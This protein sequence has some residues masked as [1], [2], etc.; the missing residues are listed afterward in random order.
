MKII[1]KYSLISLILVTL[2]GCGQVKF[3]G[4]NSSNN[5]DGGNNGGGGTVNPNEIRDVVYSGTVQAKNNKIDILLVIDDSNSMLDD[6]K[7]LAS[8]LYTF[9]TALQ[10]L[11]LDWQMCVTLTRQLNIAGN[12]HWGASLHWVN[13]VPQSGVT[14]LVLKPNPANLANIFNSTI[15][16]IGAGWAGTDDERGIMAA[17]WHVANSQ[18]NGC[19]RSDAAL[20]TII[21]SDEDVRSVG[22]D[23][24]L[25]YYANE[26]KELEEN[27]KPAAYVGQV[28]T[29]LGEQKRFTV[30]SIIVND[31]T[32]MTAQDTAGSKSHTG[33]HYAELSTLTGGGVGSIC[34]ADYSANL[35]YFKD[36][37]QNSLASIPLECAPV[38]GV[39]VN[40]TPPMG[41]VTS[42]VQG[43]S[44]VFSPE[45]PTGRTYEVK[46]KCKGPSLMAN[47]HPSSEE[48]QGFFA[49]LY[50]WIVEPILNL[51]K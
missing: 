28:K 27:D 39:S 8:R 49:K 29:V 13:Y 16:Q 50:A 9:V 48:P 17:N 6:N 38:N 41:N 18:Y 31:S 44:L 42:T 36:L 51:F 4:D 30:N 33:K 7:K 24:T 45:I 5:G 21:I 23:Q 15:D 22:G 25:Q 11:Q 32:C 14:P 40:I 43:M 37:I 47:R 20:S 3:S 10:S 34:D 46:Y 26:Y 2:M 1:S 19:Y 12:L 35:N